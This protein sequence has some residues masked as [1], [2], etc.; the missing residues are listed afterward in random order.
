MTGAIAVLSKKQAEEIIRKAY[1]NGNFVLAEPHFTESMKKRNVIIRDILNV[2]EKF[3]IAND[4]QWN[5][6]FEQYRC[7]V[8]GKNIEGIKLTVVVGI[9]PDQKDSIILLT[10]F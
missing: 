2:M 4:P 1:H 9:L 6:D 5:S 3:Q 7:R 8:V 10:V